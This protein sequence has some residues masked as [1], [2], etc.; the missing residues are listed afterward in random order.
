MAAPTNAALVK[1][2]LA[3]PEDVLIAVQNVSC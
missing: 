1:K 2:T 3:N